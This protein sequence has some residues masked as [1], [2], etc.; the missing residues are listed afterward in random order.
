MAGWVD[1]WVAVG[2]SKTG[3]GMAAGS[4]ADDSIEGAG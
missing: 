1:G 2:V 3:W 4:K